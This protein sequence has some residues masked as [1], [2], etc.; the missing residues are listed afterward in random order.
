MARAGGRQREPSGRDGGLTPRKGEQEGR[1]VQPHSEKVSARLMGSS[2][3]RVAC[4]TNPTSGQNIAQ[5]WYSCHAQSLGGKSP[6]KCG[7]A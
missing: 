1:G 3:D 5:F 7:L 4:W 6:G 2:G